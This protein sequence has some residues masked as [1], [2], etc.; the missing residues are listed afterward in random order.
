MTLPK[1]VW[2]PNFGCHGEAVSEVSLLGK[3][4]AYEIRLPD[5]STA[6]LPTEDITQLE[7]NHASL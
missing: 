3:K 2:L 4:T 7:K 5:G 1:T 6:F